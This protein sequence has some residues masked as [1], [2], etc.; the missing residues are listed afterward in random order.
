[1]RR[2]VIRLLFSAYAL[3]LALVV[4][5]ASSESYGAFQQLKSTERAFLRATGTSDL[6]GGFKYVLRDISELERSESEN[7]HLRAEDERSGVVDA[8]RVRLHPP[9]VTSE[10]D[11]STFFR[12][13]SV[14]QQTSEVALAILIN[15]RSVG[16]AEVEKE[17]VK[18]VELLI[19]FKQNDLPLP[20]GF[21]RSDFKVRLDRA[22]DYLK[23]VDSSTRTTGETFI[24]PLVYLVA[25]A[26][27]LWMFWVVNIH[28]DVL[29]QRRHFLF[30]FLISLAVPAFWYAFSSFYL[31]YSFGF[32]LSIWGMAVLLIA[33]IG[34]S[35]TRFYLAAVVAKLRN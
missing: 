23:Q 4:Y 13:A 22:G 17:A 7:E 21:W 31:S 30:G 27:M 15:A 10:F 3:L 14:W 6:M 33:A 11:T 2:A 20:N 32:L 16:Y 29:Q 35:A 26:F 1:M 24:V 8:N 5:G 19:A 34:F 18:V 12:R 9:S 25:T 28:G